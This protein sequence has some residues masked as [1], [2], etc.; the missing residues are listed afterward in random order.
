MMTR[1]WF[2]LVSSVGLLALN[3]AGCASEAPDEP[4]DPQSVCQRFCANTRQLSCPNVNLCVSQ[5]LDGRKA[6][7]P[8]CLPLTD[9]T[10]R[11]YAARP[12]TDFYC[13]P[14]LSKPVPLP[15]VCADEVAAQTSCATGR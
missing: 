15:G 2:S 5:C 10:M 4:Q 13:D 12:A 14:I 1:V 9:A 3:V 8:N 7:S 6:V 11:C